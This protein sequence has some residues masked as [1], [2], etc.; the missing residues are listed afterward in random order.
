VVT[1][2]V[3]VGWN[4]E[5]RQNSLSF[6]SGS[7][8]A[9]DYQEILAKS[10]LPAAEAMFESR[11][12]SWELQQDKASCH[13]AKSTKKWLADQGVAVLDSWPTKGD[14]INPIE[15]LWAILDERLSRRRFTTLAGMKKTLVQEWDILSQDLLDNLINAIPDRLRRITL[16]SGGSI[17]RVK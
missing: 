11:G 5:E 9:V 16:A 14:D 12:N 17:K 3:C 6:Y 10:L 4:L 2:T 15:N 8:T 13:T 7:L 1:N